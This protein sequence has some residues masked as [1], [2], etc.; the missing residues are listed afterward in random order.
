MKKSGTIY[1]ASSCDKYLLERQSFGAQRVWEKVLEMVWTIFKRSYFS[2]Y[3]SLAVSS[4]SPFI[5]ILDMDHYQRL[6]ARLN[7]VENPNWKSISNVHRMLR[8]NATDRPT[9]HPI[10]VSTHHKAFYHLSWNTSG[11]CAHASS[12]KCIGMSIFLSVCV[13]VSGWLAGIQKK[14]QMLNIFDELY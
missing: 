10:H 14:R 6:H 13:C 7:K 1:G 11:F 5:I 9:D 3:F 12:Y 4:V 2:L 8:W